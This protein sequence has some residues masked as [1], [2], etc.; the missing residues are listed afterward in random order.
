MEKINI[1]NSNQNKEE[2]EK[3][4]KQDITKF[5]SQ[6]KNGCFRKNCYN[7]YCKNSNGKFLI[8]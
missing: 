2:I 7:P 1:E 8:F 4:L 6:I 3:K 5:Y